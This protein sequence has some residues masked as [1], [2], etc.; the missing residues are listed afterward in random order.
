ITNLKT[1][2]LRGN[3]LK[4]FAPSFYTPFKNLEVLDIGNNFLTSLNWTHMTQTLKSLN[5][6]RLDHNRMQIISESAETLFQTVNKLHL[7]FNK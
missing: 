6:L 4:S 1:L 5:D 3:W 7:G 2:I